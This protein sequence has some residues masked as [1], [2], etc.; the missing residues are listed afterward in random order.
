MLIIADKIEDLVKMVAKNMSN[1]DKKEF[2][3]HINTD[4]SER[5]SK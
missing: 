4:P 1:Q 3:S 2:L 5:L